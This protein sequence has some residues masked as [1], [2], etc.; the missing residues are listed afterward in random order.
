MKI[1]VSIPRGTNLA[2]TIGLI[3]AKFSFSL[4][5]SLVGPTS[6]QPAHPALD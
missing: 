2:A 3:V 5:Q 6:L 1:D 4:F